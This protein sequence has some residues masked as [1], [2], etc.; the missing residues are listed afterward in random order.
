MEIVSSTSANCTISALEKIFS[1]HGLP[2]RIISDNGPL[3]K[4]CQISTYKKNSRIT[5]DRIAFPH[6]RAN[7]IVENFKC[8]LNKTLR[9]AS[10]QKRN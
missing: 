10:M 2:Q 9:I 1:E 8:N 5:H 3:F 7:G 6:Y 4:S